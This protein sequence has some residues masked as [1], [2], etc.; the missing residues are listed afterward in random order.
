M[1]QTLRYALRTMAGNPGFTA[2]AVLTLALGIGANSAIFSVVHALLLRSLPLR[3]P[4]RLV[5]VSIT[6]QQRNLQSVPFSL[7]AYESIRD[8]NRSF[9]GI[10]AF[11]SDTFTLTGGEQ[12]EQ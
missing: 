3:D 1:P 11:T 9:S 10:A 2:V 6:N 5:L 12:P 8:R 4:D 7:A